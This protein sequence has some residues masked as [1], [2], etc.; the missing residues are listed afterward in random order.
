M[1]TRRRRIPIAVAD[2]IANATAGLVP[3][4][5]GFSRS[6]VRVL[7]IVLAAVLAVTGLSLAEGPSGAPIALRGGPG[8]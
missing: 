1:R 7:G 2:S 5:R 6:H 4:G 8:A 3:F